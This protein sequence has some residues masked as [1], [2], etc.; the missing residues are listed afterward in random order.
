MAT[1][2]VGVYRKYRGP[3]PV[4]KSGNPL[5]KHDWANKRPFSW[6]ARWFGIDGK[7]YSKSF[8]TRKEAERFAE[9]KQQDVRQGKA[10]PPKRVTLREFYQEHRRLMKGAV[11]KTTLHMQLAVLALLAEV[12]GWDR[13]MR[14][15]STRD[16]EQFRANRSEAGNEPATVNKEVRALKRLFNLAISRGYLAQGTNPSV[17][18]P[19]AKCGRKRVPYCP[20]SQLDSV[21]S[22]APSLLWRAMLVVFY[23]AGLRLREALNLTWTDV[24][25]SAGKVHITRKKSRGFVQAWAPKDHEC[26]SVPLPPQAIDLLTK[27]QAEAPEQCPYV[28][29]EPDRWDYYRQQ[30]EAKE[31]KPGQDL[32]NNVLRRFKTLCRRAEVG[33]YTIHDLRRSCITNW[34]RYLAIHV[35]Q[36]W[37]GHGDIKTTQEFYLSVQDEDV[38]KTQAGQAELMDGIGI[39]EVTDPKVTH[40]PQKRTFPKR[41]VFSGVSQPPEV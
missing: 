37:A 33:P 13:E 31:W 10:D 14:R 5:P 30:V 25:F 41:K 32:S 1:E 23:T 29:M 39:E 21:Y 35:T 8:K 17:G 22:K 16:I 12:V 36:Q 11:A 26:R 4:D 19:M 28:F 2:R 6:A 7:R 20:V 38:V 40:K 18:V 9:T 34:A 3:I 15:I 24:D 27:L